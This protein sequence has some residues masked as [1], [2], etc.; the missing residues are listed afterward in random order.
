MINVLQIP[1]LTA[2]LSKCWKDAES[3]LQAE[4]NQYAPSASE[5]LITQNFHKELSR[6]LSAAS[7]NRSIELAFLNDL[8]RSG[9][10]QKVK[11][12]SRRIARGLIAEVTLHKPET[13]K[14]SGGDLG[15]VVVRPQLQLAQR[16]I[17]ISDMR[18]GLLVQAKLKGP[19]RWGTFTRNQECVLPKRMNYLALLLYQYADAERRLLNSFV[20]QLADGMSFEDLKACLK[21]DHF[22]N[23]LDS[24][25]V[26]AGLT[27]GRIGT[28]ERQL[29][30]TLISPD[31]NRALIIR[32]HWSDGEPPSSALRVHGAYETRQTVTNVISR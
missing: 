3:D 17:N 26:I 22:P 27:S 31:H 13:E 19:R 5:E 11:F 15:L 30:D 21:R 2:L 7:A 6:I 20:W 14:L 16:A 4:I 28:A 23:A 25:R 10:G 29:I 24:S 8:D 1:R 9:W 12:D 32:I 18:Q